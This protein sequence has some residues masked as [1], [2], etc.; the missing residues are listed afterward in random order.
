MNSSYGPFDTRVGVLQRAA[1]FAD[2]I[3]RHRLDTQMLRLWGARSINDSYGDPTG[4]GVGGTGGVQMLEARKGDIAR[5]VS[6]IARKAGMVEESRKGQ[7]SFQLDI[8]DFLDPTGGGSIGDFGPD[9]E[10]FFVRLQERRSGRWLANPAGAAIDPNLPLRGPIAVVMNPYSYG[11]VVA[12]ISFEGTAPSNTG[13]TAGA[14]PVLD[15]TQQ[16]PT[17]MIISLPW[18]VTGGLIRN[19]EGAA[20]L[21]MGYG[22]GRPMVEIAAGEAL[23]IPFPGGAQQIVLART[24]GAG[25]AD[26]YADFTLARQAGF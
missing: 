18:S 11:G 4:S 19:K 8:E 1:N 13:C 3:V 20:T 9:E 7:T 15:E 14:A 21:L 16:V 6:V 26:F 24:T 2:L 22:L 23:E 12:A 25:G 10:V 5:S 17:P